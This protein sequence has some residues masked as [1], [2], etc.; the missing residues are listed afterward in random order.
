MAEHNTL[1]D[2]IGWIGAI[3][4]LVAY[5]LVSTRKTEGDSVVYQSLN[6]VGSAFLMG[7]AFFYGAYPSS[8]VNVIWIGIALFT[9][10]RK[11]RT[12]ISR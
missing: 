9:L 8:A 5:A 1:I 10:A 3:V 2:L 7:N 4:L 12:G 6:V 11:K